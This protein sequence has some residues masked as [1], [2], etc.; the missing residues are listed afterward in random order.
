M[1]FR[2]TAEMRRMHEAER[3][4][5]LEARRARNREFLEHVRWIADR[6]SREIRRVVL[7]QAP[8]EE[9]FR[10]T[11]PNYLHVL[12]RRAWEEDRWED[13]GLLLGALGFE[14]KAETI[15]VAESI[16]PRMFALEE[17]LTRSFEP[18]TGAGRSARREWWYQSSPEAIAWL[19]KQVLDGIRTPPDRRRVPLPEGKYLDAQH[20][21]A[22][23][24]KY[25]ER[26]LWEFLLRE[27]LR[28]ILSA[29]Q[30]DVVWFWSQFHNDARPRET[31]KA[32]AEFL[33]L[34]PPTVRWHKAEAAKNPELRRLFGLC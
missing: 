2:I 15:H 11:S 27:D 5:D 31:T 25:L 3:H 29:Q 34:A 4:L 10:P 28:R 13:W 6:P 24:S 8:G 12:A 26:E 1:P 17:Q 32:V 30:A 7:G 18:K 33:Q 9:R 14:A 16:A 19:R 21:H 23:N 20:P 22:G